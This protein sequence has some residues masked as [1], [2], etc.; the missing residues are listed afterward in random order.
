MDKRNLMIKDQFLKIAFILDGTIVTYHT[1]TNLT[2]Y[3]AFFCGE[4]VKKLCKKYKQ[5]QLMVLNN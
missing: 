3:V 5:K 4:M 2:I 1:Y